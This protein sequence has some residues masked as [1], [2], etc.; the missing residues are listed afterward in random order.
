MA[1]EVHTAVIPAA[2]L[3]TRFLPAT[4]AIPKELMP[5][6]DRP[7]IHYVAQE[8]MAAGID[9]IAIVTAEGKGALEQYFT[10][11]PHIEQMMRDRDMNDAADELRQFAERLRFSYPVQEEQLGLGHAVLCAKAVVG[12]NPFAVLLP[13]D[14]LVGAEPVLAQMLHAW[15]RHPGNYLA[16]EVAPLDRISSYGVV[17][18][19]PEGHLDEHTYRLRG[20]VEKPTADQA[21][22]NLVI[23]GR[24][25]LMPEVFDALERTPPGAIGEIQLT[26][27]IALAMERQPTYAYRFAATRYDC[28]TPLGLLRTSLAMALRRPDIAPQ[29][30][31]WL[32]EFGL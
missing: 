15:R 7:A 14:L 2:G 31:K 8:A 17:D 16:V 3:G 4:K 19:A 26:D 24:Y 5:L 22:S 29:V 27:A 9:H 32:G 20:V 10:S 25:I 6:V 12:D 11:A 13:D 1:T 18:L 28:G 30:R 23:V 21:P